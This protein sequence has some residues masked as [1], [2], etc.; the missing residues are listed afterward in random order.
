MRHG[1]FDAFGG[2]HAAVRA[3]AAGQ[4]VDACFADE[5]AVDFPSLAPA[6][7]RMRRP[8]VADLR[9][10]A[11][12]TIIQLSRQEALAGTTVSLQV[13]L[14]SECRPCGG[15]GE[16]WAGPCPTCGGAGVTLRYR[17]VRVAV[18]AGV[19]DGSWH[20]MT[21]APGQTPPTRIE[22]QVLVA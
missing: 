20:R 19:R 13:P 5:V 14:R 7:R 12:S 1:T 22:L 15:R 8:F 2:D 16:S 18:P 6:V 10:V 21:I 3:T 9:P 4:P 11:L 17:I